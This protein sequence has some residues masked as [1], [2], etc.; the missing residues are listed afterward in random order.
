MLPPAHTSGTGVNVGGPQF[1]PVDRC[2]LENGVELSL[3]SI[4]MPGMTLYIRAEFGP[5]LYLRFENIWLRRAHSLSDAYYRIKRWLVGAAD[6]KSGV[7]FISGPEGILKLTPP[8]MFT[9]RFGAGGFVADNAVTATV[10]S[11]MDIQELRN[12]QRQ[13]E[14]SEPLAGGNAA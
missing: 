11:S 1:F 6:V 2:V 3:P 9:Y 8:C 12:R 14:V 5:M 4:Q 13:P 10:S 7:C